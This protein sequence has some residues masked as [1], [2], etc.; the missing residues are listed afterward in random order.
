MDQDNVRNNI[1]T[2][3]ITLTRSKLVIKKD[4]DINENTSFQDDLNA[5]SIDLTDLVMEIETTFKIKISDRDMEKI[6]TVRDAVDLICAK[7][8]Q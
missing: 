4:I 6:K 1:L 8:S 3:L 2:Q 5:D 7:K